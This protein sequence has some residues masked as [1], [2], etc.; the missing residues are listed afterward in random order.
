MLAL[1][2]TRGSHPLV[3]TRRLLLAAASAGV[4]F[5]LLCTLGY[6]SGHPAAASSSVLRLLWCAVPLAATVQFAV[7]VAR[8]DPS[9]RPRPGL[10]AA[11]LGPAR[12]SLLAAISTAVSTTLGSMV[13][14]LFF[15]H[16]R[17][18]LTGLPFDG[19]AA[20]FLGADAPLPLA[21]TLTLLALVPLAASTAGG[22][23]VRSRPVA[24]SEA[25]EAEDDLAPAPVPK[26]LPWGVALTAAGLAVEAYASRGTAGDPFPL[27]GRLDSTPGA[28]LAGWILTA[29][30]LAMAGPGLTHLCGRLLQ[31]VRPGAVRLLAGRVLM[32][33]AT[34]IG[35]P[36]GIV[37]AVLSGVIAAS[38]L[39]TGGPRPFGPL[40]A[41]GAVLVLGCTTATLLTTAIEARQ[42]RARTATTLLR[43]GAPASMLRTAA[44]LRAL[45]LLAVFAPLTWAIA[46]LAALPLTE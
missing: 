18:D 4:G 32:D 23:A 20:E 31:A 39:Y 11:G 35:R 17:G 16:L 43:L 27:P 40:T 12:L 45:V 13:A 24:P 22:L 29:I 30:G 5:L 36:L 26:G 19:D 10:F 25:H 34:R 33:E 46:E 2:L 8:T 28:V 6:A 44:V 41:L 3:L 21:A 15:L 14:L 42:S 1:R 37:C 38:V 9:T 7:A